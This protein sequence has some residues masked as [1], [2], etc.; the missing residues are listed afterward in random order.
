VPAALPSLSRFSCCHRLSATLT[1]PLPPPRVV[2]RQL[3]HH[4]TG[5]ICGGE[6][7]EGATVEEG[8]PPS[9]SL[10]HRRDPPL[11]PEPRRRPL[12]PAGEP[13][14]TPLFSLPRPTAACVSLRG[15]VRTTTPRHPISIQGPHGPSGHASPGPH[16]APSPLLF[17]FSFI[18][19]RHLEF[20]PGPAHVSNPRGPGTFPARLFHLKF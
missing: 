17:F 3:H 1:I 2:G 10:H 8:A 16:R 20:S 9:P 4:C 18:S 6:P 12:R 7:P 11:S 19:Y 5:R 14:P 15:V 13:S